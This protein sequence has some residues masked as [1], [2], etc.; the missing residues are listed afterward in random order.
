MNTCIYKITNLVNGK[1]YIGQTIKNPKDRFIRHI[2]EAVNK[3]NKKSLVLNAIRKYGKDNFKFDIIKSGNFNRQLLDELE[4]HY[5][6]L[7]NSTNKNT[8]YNILKGGNGYDR[9]GKKV[10]QYDIEGNF[11]NEFKSIMEAGRKLNINSHGISVCC[12]EKTQT[13]RGFR[14]KFYKTDKLDKL[15]LRKKREGTKFISIQNEATKEVLS[16]KSK[17]EGSIFLGHLRSYI[18]RQE[19]KAKEYNRVVN[20]YDKNKNKYIII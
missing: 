19:H 8:G 18:S 3:K 7:Y 12:L 1:I 9:E 14:F 2:Y 20:L 5:I 15:S 16:F 17:T 11:I 13:S 4:I 6:Q 10:Y